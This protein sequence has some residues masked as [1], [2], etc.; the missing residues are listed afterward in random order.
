MKKI[1][2]PPQ[3]LA[4]HIALIVGLGF[5]IL[6]GLREYIPALIGSVILFVL[7]RRFFHFL[8]R[9]RRWGKGLSIGV[10]FVS[11]LFVIVLPLLLVGIMIARKAIAYSTKTDALVDAFNQ[12]LS[13]PMVI[14]V[15]E[16][17]G[18][19]LQNKELLQQVAT[20]VGTFATEL[21][22][23]LLSGTLS[24]F[25]SISILYFIL[26]YLF[27]DEDRVITQLHK[28]L[29]FD[30]ATIDEMYQELANNV[31]ASVLGQGLIALVQAS[32]TGLGFLI[33]GINDAFFW[34][35]VAFFTAFIPVL[36]TPLV[37]VPAGV[38]EL[39]QGDQFSGFGI[40]IWGAVLVLNIDNFLR[41]AIAKHIGDIHPLIT[42]L[43]V[44]FGLQF[45][46]I[47]GLVMGPLLI[48]Y[49]LV[50]V[51]AYQREYGPAVAPPLPPPA[52]GQE[53]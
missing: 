37:W 38:I 34:G 25:V 50:L 43:G 6:Y 18:I 35:V 24:L 41:F 31:T 47:L 30:D 20:R 52:E 8:Y 9:R 32:L 16:L 1:Y 26:F 23:P 33:F 12:L 17:A 7:F 21:F 19:D 48:S 13:N 2:S 39:A 42:I 11:S 3:K 44:I 53:L 40:L 4:L 29:P 46:G 10:V 49:F 15:Q 14:R 5:F 28:F 27:Y 22:T 36:G 51:K 45:F